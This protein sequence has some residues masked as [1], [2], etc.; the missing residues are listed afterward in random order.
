[1]FTRFRGR[2]V[3]PFAV[4]TAAFA[5]P[6]RE[7]KSLAKPNL[8]GEHHFPAELSHRLKR[9]PGR[10]KKGVHRAD[11]VAVLNFG[12]TL[13]VI[14]AVA[15]RPSPVRVGARQVVI[16]VALLAGIAALPSPAHAADLLKPATLGAA[17]IPP[18]LVST[19][20]HR[21]D[22]ATPL[23]L[24]RFESQA[25]L[26]YGG[27]AFF[28]N[29]RTLNLFMSDRYVYDG[30]WLQAQADWITRYLHYGSELEA[31]T[32]YTVTQE[33]VAA[34]CGA[35]AYGC[36]SPSSQILILP[37]NHYADGT[38]IEQILMHEYG[39]HIARNRDN[40][41]WSAS[42]YG[43][44][45]WATATNVCGR[46]LT[47]TAFPGD[48]GTNY[49]LNPGEVFAETYSKLI[50]RSVTWTSPWLEWPWYWDGSFTPTEDTYSAASADVV[51]PWSPPAVTPWSGQIKRAQVPYK[52]R[53]PYRVKV[54]Y[55]VKV[56][57]RIN[58]Q[59]NWLTRTRAVKRT[60]KV[61]RFR[62]VTRYRTG[63]IE[64]PKMTI[65]TPLDGIMTLT[66]AAP[67]GTTMVLTDAVTGM[68]LAPS[69]TS[70]I[71]QG[72]CGYRSFDLTLVAS[73][74]GP[75]TVAVTAP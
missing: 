9:A 58:V 63:A 39:H 18:S 13:K 15:G 35:N 70:Y 47:G 10:S 71:T 56:K 53:V 29:G 32:F 44:K 68:Q 61:T 60:K 1:M 59:G 42:D 54:G 17:Y 62:T 24:R 51:S 45:R 49:R 25:T 14:L 67:P 7:R 33:E 28:S 50:W 64:N 26:S 34:V 19:Q 5:F 20:P 46:T 57:Y 73:A 74:T 2:S 69:S 65:D 66:L 23:S 37:G 43:P 55:T 48:E 31:A 8:V 27:G 3:R 11:A 52:V 16:V 36:Y 72:V 75:F 38:R 4:I 30:A 21:F 41:P 12:G 6:A 22:G 40:A